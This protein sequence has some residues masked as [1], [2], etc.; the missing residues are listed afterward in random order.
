MWE[1]LFSQLGG[2]KRRYLAHLFSFSTGLQWNNYAQAAPA[3]G[4]KPSNP[5]PEVA[6]A[7]LVDAQR[8]SS[9]NC[10]V[11]IVGRFLMWCAAQ[12]YLVQ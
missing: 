1:S 9:N 4:A 7:L 10:E 8:A 5:L 2:F 11:K 6:G 12:W 3:A